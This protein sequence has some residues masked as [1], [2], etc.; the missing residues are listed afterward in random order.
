ISQLVSNSGELLRSKLGLKHLST[1]SLGY[2]R[3]SLP[4]NLTAARLYTEGTLALGHF[5]PKEASIL[6]TEAAQIEPQHA[7]THAALSTAWAALGY[8]QRSQSEAL[9]AEDLA[10]GLSPIQQ[11]EYRGLANQARNDWPAAIET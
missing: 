9:L 4:T 1:Q 2:L 10:R 11:L 8:Q 7:P 5:E 6:L 3:S